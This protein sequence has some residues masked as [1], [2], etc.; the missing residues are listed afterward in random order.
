MPLMESISEI[1]KT[2]KGRPEGTTILSKDT[3]TFKN[4]LNGVKAAGTAEKTA[5]KTTAKTV[6]GTAGNLDSI[7]KKAASTYGVSEKLLKSVAKTES[8]FQVT[9]VSKAGAMGIM[10]LMPATAK[11]LGVSDPFDPEQNIMG[12]A[13]LLAANIKEFGGDLKLALAAYN[14]GSGAVRKYDGVPPYEETQN[15]VKKIMAD[16]QSDAAIDI[17]SVLGTVSEAGSGFIGEGSSVDELKSLIS[18]LGFGSSQNSGMMG[19]NTIFSGLLNKEIDETGT[20]DKEMFANF[21]E[22]LRL[23]MLMN[24]TNSIGDMDFDDD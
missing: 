19:I 18:T 21:I 7:F 1:N 17:N 8:D 4:V 23:Q 5:E 13:K 6:S 16:L 14:A 2:G 22:I 11:E 3:K 10:Q 12:G 9:A 15:Y 20:V 24:T